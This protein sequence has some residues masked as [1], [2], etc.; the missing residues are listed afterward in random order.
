MCG[1]WYVCVTRCVGA[2]VYVS[3]KKPEVGVEHLP[4][5]LSTLDTKAECALLAP[6][7]AYSNSSASQLALGIPSP[8]CPSG[9]T[10]GPPSPSSIY[11]VVILMGQALDLTSHLPNPSNGF[12]SDDFSV[13][14][15]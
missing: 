8:C 13:C 5:L 9:I 2:S 4:K 10:G 14:L 12:L 1:V 15:G 6:E 7:L 3:M 11:V